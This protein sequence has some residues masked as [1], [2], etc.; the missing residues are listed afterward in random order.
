VTDVRDD[1]V[2]DDPAEAFADQL[3]GRAE[4]GEEIDLDA[5]LAHL[6]ATL[7]QRVLSVLEKTREVYAKLDMSFPLLMTEA[8]R[9]AGYRLGR[10]IGEGGMAKV[11]VAT[12]E[13]TKRK[14]AL[15]L[16]V[17][18]A[19]TAHLSARFRDEQRWA[20]L[21]HPA[22][23]R[24]YGAGETDDVLFLAMERVAGPSL[25]QVIAA[26]ADH[27][28]DTIL[29]LPSIERT[30]AHLGMREGVRGPATP[31][32]RFGRPNYVRWCCEVAAEVAAALA[33]AHD[34]DILHRDVK[35]SNILLHPDGHPRLADFG[36]A[37]KQT[38]P[39]VTRSF[40][41]PGT[42]VYMSPQQ[43]DP[44]E[45]VVD[46]RADV[47]ALGVT[48][49]ELLT[50]ERPFR[51]D[52]ETTL[53]GAI[54]TRRATSPER[55]NC[56]IPRDL[57]AIVMRALEKDPAHR[58][59]TAREMEDDLRAFMAGHKVKANPVGLAT[60]VVRRLRRDRHM[61]RFAT[62]VLV[63]VF[64]TVL[65]A[66]AGWI[67]AGVAADRTAFAQLEPAI[68]TAVRKVGDSVARG[69]HPTAR[70]Q[71]NTVERLALQ[72]QSFVSPG[73]SSWNLL[74]EKRL[75]VAVE[76]NL[77]EGVQG[78][79][80]DS[81]ITESVKRASE[82]NLLL[83]C[84]R[85]A[86]LLD[87]APHR[88]LTLARSAFQL[89]SSNGDTTTAR[90]AA[91]I[92]AILKAISESTTIRAP[93]VFDPSALPGDVIVIGPRDDDLTPHVFRWRPGT[94]W[95][96]AECLQKLDSMYSPSFRTYHQVTVVQTSTEEALYAVVGVDEKVVTMRL[97]RDT[98]T[99]TLEVQRPIAVH[100]CGSHRVRAE[101]VLAGFHDD[102]A[103]SSVL[104]LVRDGELDNDSWQLDID[105][106]GRI[107]RGRRLASARVNGHARP[108]LP[109]DPGDTI[110]LGLGEWIE[111]FGV[112]AQLLGNGQNDV[113]RCGH[114]SAL[115]GAAPDCFI[116]AKSNREL[117]RDFLGHSRPLGW[118][119][120]LYLC[121]MQ[122]DLSW[123]PVLADLTF[124]PVQNKA[125]LPGVACVRSAGITLCMATSIDDH[126]THDGLEMRFYEV[127]A[128]PPNR[129][130]LQPW[131]PLL[132]VST[133]TGDMTGP[134]WI[135]DLDGDGHQDI[136]QWRHSE[137]TRAIEILPIPLGRALANGSI[138]DALTQPPPIPL[139][140]PPIDRSCL[141]SVDPRI[142]IRD[143]G[144]LQLD[145]VS[146][147]L[148]GAGTYVKYHGGSFDVVIDVTPRWIDDNTSVR[149]GLRTKVFGDAHAQEV[150]AEF[151][152]G[153]GESGMSNAITLTQTM[154][155]SPLHA[156][157]SG[158]AYVL[159]AC[160]R[161]R[162]THDAT[163]QTLVVD[164]RDPLRPNKVLLAADYADVRF[165]PGTF[166]V[167]LMPRMAQEHPRPR[168]RAN[169]CIRLAPHEVAVR[170]LKAVDL[171]T[172]HRIAWGL[173][174][175][176]DS[177]P[178]DLCLSME[179][180]E[181][182][183]WHERERGYEQAVLMLKRAG[184]EEVTPLISGR[185]LKALLK[186]RDPDA[187]LDLAVQCRAGHML[188]GFAAQPDRRWWAELAQ[189]M[190]ADGQDE[191]VDS[192]RIL[193]VSLQRALQS[194]KGYRRSEELRK[195]ASLVRGVRRWLHFASDELNAAPAA[196][197]GPGA[198]SAAAITDTANRLH[199]RLALLGFG[200]P[201]Q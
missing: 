112:L 123:K 54:C 97:R 99:N 144:T 80:T 67:A 89:A 53:I 138:P 98:Q 31:S 147:W 1:R 26:L 14:V 22:I 90:A 64:I 86:A 3:V 118:D 33:Y 30:L 71:A 109:R 155:L 36:L 32:E 103:P 61:R 152:V 40:E 50:L 38:E 135:A 145:G 158:N 78:T 185:R 201:Q 76:A 168:V 198:T 13:A 122:G 141:V 35:P 77:V 156:Q 43:L 163:K 178:F 24:V 7:R 58:Y 143:D 120:G 136:C 69:D 134:L 139:D 148:P 115:C 160:H 18:S 125:N 114:V 19:A 45:G 88:G 94:P 84:A 182:L 154:S 79:L 10:L 157:V 195:M 42:A 63:A 130:T 197:D 106:A 142:A 39:G 192:D 25:A 116:L 194:V 179:R 119:R 108:S 121:H 140:V 92:V 75:E 190:R 27:D 105:R 101:L 153:G 150:L 113:V 91:L 34:A 151:G 81:L 117:C 200:Q 21:E 29:R 169:V 173:E 177:D 165:D 180:N 171:P 74:Q 126:R 2:S 191:A 57:A 68:E 181:T 56:A 184:L 164:L 12:E 186:H 159:D 176:D 9:I 127:P 170:P 15:K 174:P 85:A 70:A 23:V 49:Y 104:W 146:S 95:A 110:L 55:L 28:P 167:G 8:R 124:D 20:V 66:T 65:L 72:A 4:G 41:R 52:S 5:E 46:W 6:P 199:R 93:G 44:A 129:D 73:S 82:P 100:P 17:K 193:A 107:S 83:A 48:L 196:A 59:A 172:D 128:T 96:T 189:V 175:V 149:V 187:I 132:R 102:R 37:R 51:S 87:G 131:Q 161:L 166:F 183:S 11:Y 133:K 62:A 137:K 162:I 60:R 47:Y 111:G 188:Q 16:L